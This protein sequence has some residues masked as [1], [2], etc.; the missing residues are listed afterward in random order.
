MYINPPIFPVGTWTDPDAKAHS[1]IPI[2]VRQ[3]PSAAARPINTQKFSGTDK[4]FEI[5]P[6][7]RLALSMDPICFENIGTRLQQQEV[8][9][10]NTAHA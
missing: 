3:R 10:L 5:R 4:T 7:S 2:G 9:D 1:G 6:D 8:A